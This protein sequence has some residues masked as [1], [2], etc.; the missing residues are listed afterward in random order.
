MFDAFQLSDGTFAG[1]GAHVVNLTSINAVI[2][3]EHF[4][5]NGNRSP[6]LRELLA[7]CVL[8]RAQWVADVSKCRKG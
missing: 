8:S 1:F 5:G 3:G 4:D 6:I 7:P 2:V